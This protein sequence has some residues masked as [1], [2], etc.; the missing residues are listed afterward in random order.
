MTAGDTHRTVRQKLT[1]M[2]RT[3]WGEGVV[4]TPKRMGILVLASKNSEHA[5][6]AIFLKS[7]SFSSLHHKSVALCNF[8]TYTFWLMWTNWNLDKLQPQLVRIPYE[9]FIPCSFVLKL[10]LWLNFPNVAENC[11]HFLIMHQNVISLR[12]RIISIKEPWRFMKH[13]LCL[14]LNKIEINSW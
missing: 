5:A 11:S 3:V 8:S 7:R 10:K 6:S 4:L 12:N 1:V 9:G 2:N 14:R 13:L